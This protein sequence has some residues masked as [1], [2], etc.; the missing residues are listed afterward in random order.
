MSEKDGKTYRIPI[1]STSNILN[2]PHNIMPLDQVKEKIHRGELTIKDILDND[3]FINDLRTNP[4]SPYR[5]MITSDNIKL[6]IDYCLKFNKELKESSQS[7]LRYPYYS[8]QILCSPCVLLFKQSISNIRHSNSLI[9][10]INKIIDNEME[11]KINNSNYS[12]EKLESNKNNNKEYNINKSKSNN[13][14]IDSSNQ[15]YNRDFYNDYNSNFIND[16]VNDIDEKYV[17]SYKNLTETDLNRST[18]NNK[19]NIKY[20]D[21]EM[22]IIKEILNHIFG[23]LNYQ[24]NNKIFEENLAYWGYFKN[25][26]NYLL[27]N[28]TDIMIE[29]LFEDSTPVIDKFYSNLNNTSIQIILENLLNILSDNEDKKFNDKY[30]DIIMKLIQTLSEDSFNGNFENSEY[31]CELIINTLIN[32]TENQL[33]DLIIKNNSIMIKIKNIINHIVDIK[34]NE[35]IL[36]ENKRKLLINILKL[37]CKINNIILISLNESFSNKITDIINDY[38]KLN[39]FE[40][41]YFCTKKISYKNIFDAFKENILSYYF[42]LEEIYK[43]I[44]K[45]I[46]QKYEINKLNQDINNLNN[47]NNNKYIKKFGLHNIYEWKFI[48]ST[49]KV[50]LNYYTVTDKMKNAKYFDDKE[51]LLLSIELYF[52]YP[53][54]NI[55]QNIFHEIIKLI[56]LEECPYH[57]IEPFLIIDN[58][59]KQNKF[60]FNL[61]DNIK[62]NKDKIYNS[63]IGIDLEILKLF[64]SSNNKAIL[65]HFKESDLD[66][67]Y[68][69][70]FIKDSIKNRLDKQLNEDYEY[71]NDEIF[72]IEKDKDDTF[73]GNDCEINKEFL[74]FKNIISNFLDKVEEEEEKHINK[75][76][77]GNNNKNQLNI[78]EKKKNENEIQ[79][80]KITDIFIYNVDKTQ[81][82]KIEEKTIEN[83]NNPEIT[84]EVKYLLEEKE[85]NI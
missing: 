52:K 84:K 41:Q 3:D 71:A 28:E 15:G 65:N 58:E 55:Y 73:D 43:L 23:I 37:L 33:I 1:A 26:V 29:Y 72:D 70:I 79:K 76:N 62:I 36:N 56:C 13:D 44:S 45:D 38:N 57:L 83:K 32:K 47:M 63:T 34:N 5:E 69:S 8:S 68:K 40:Y 21:E 10:N 12:N 61:L 7:D 66:N 4:I 67:K 85:S 39:I 53:Q 2:D 30:E 35:T 17:D 9:I 75:I 50:Y 46:K 11:N 81:Y 42:I 59:Q 18:M 48:L 80:T 16:Y 25:I 54:N 20:N 14:L 60:I 19:I 24:K 78:M 6:L 27:I 22:E 31:I 51:L 49:I 82:E 74:C 64:Y 77:N